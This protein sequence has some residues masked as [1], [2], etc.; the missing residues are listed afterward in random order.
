MCEEQQERFLP[1]PMARFTAG[2]LAPP[3]ARSPCPPPGPAGVERRDWPKAG[4]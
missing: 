2:T 1:D 4:V 3:G